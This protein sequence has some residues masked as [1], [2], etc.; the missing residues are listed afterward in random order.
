MI[1]V[2]HCRVF[3]TGTFS[4][5]SLIRKLWRWELKFIGCRWCRI[6]LSRCF[7]S[8]G[9]LMCL[10]MCNRKYGSG[11]CWVLP[12]W[13]LLLVVSKCFSSAQKSNLFHWGKRFFRKNSLLVARVNSVNRVKN[14]IRLNGISPWL[15]SNLSVTN[16]NNK[17]SDLIW[18]YGF[19]FLFFFQGIV[20]GTG[21]NSEFGEVFKMMQAEE[22]RGDI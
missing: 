19:F 6:P 18:L 12:V 17:T 20:I 15:D 13:V 9:T 21:E 3:L 5:T 10:K 8:R 14:C 1:S 16:T 7:A 22:V 2:I 4:C 11:Y